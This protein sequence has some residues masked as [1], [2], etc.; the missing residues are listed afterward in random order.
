[1]PAACTGHQSHGLGPLG[2]KTHFR[3]LVQVASVHRVNICDSDHPGSSS[4]AQN[5]KPMAIVFPA[6]VLTV[7][8]F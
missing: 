8:L 6:D 5:C 1:M 3:L 2:P 4:A 7:M